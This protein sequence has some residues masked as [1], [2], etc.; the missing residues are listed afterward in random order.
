[1]LHVECTAVS[2][3][4][5]VDATPEALRHRAVTHGEPASGSVSVIEAGSSSGT[6]AAPDRCP[7]SFWSVPRQPSDP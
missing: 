2:L 5:S 7:S 4:D 1:M 3:F 6:Y